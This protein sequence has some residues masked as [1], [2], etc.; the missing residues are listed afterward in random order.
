MTSEPKLDL[1]AYKLRKSIVLAI[2]FFFFNM[3]TDHIYTL[4]H[5]AI[6]VAGIKKL[7]EGN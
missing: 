2:F 6:H 1:I 3:E 5:S 4:E 7:L